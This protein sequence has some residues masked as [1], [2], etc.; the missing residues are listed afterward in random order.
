MIDVQAGE[1]Q[2]ID[3]LAPVYLALPAK[4]RGDFIIERGGTT[5]LTLEQL[6]ARAAL[7]GVTA[8]V[9]RGDPKRPVLVASWGD[10]NRV[11]RAGRRRVARMEHGIGQSKRHA[12]ATHKNP[13][14]LDVMR[15]IKGALDP[16][17]RMNPGK[18]LP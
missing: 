8:T 2:F 1:P 13:V 16:E 9:R 3:H 18:V 14:A 7:R 11:S 5:N 6:V 12:M 15:Q 10:Q 17:S 4:H